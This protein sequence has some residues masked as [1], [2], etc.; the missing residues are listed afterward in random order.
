MYRTFSAD[1]DTYITDKVIKGVRVT[2]SNVG[3]AAT[4][5]LFKLYGATLSGTIP[6]IELSR[7]LIHFDIDKIKQLYAEKKIDIEDPNFWCRI[8]LKDV[9]GGQPTPANFNVHVFPLSASFDEGIGRDVTYYT[10]RDKSNW[11]SS[12][13][14]TKWFVSGCGG[15]CFST[16]SGDYITSS[17]STGSTKV[18]QYFKV[19]TEDLVVDVTKLV[20]A[21]VVGEL[22][23]SGFRISFDNAIE[24]NNRSYF[25]KRFGS[26][27]AYDETVRPKL[28]MG[29]DDSVRDDT[30]N[31]TFDSSCR[32]SLYNFF[33]GEQKNIVSGSGLTEVKGNNCILLKLSTSSSN[34]VYELI[35]TGS[36]LA[37]GSGNWCYVSGAYF[38]D[39]VLPSNNPIIKSNLLASSS[40]KFTPI[41]SSLDGTVGYVTG[42]VVTA[43]PPVRS[44]ARP[45]SNY[46]VNVKEVKSDY[47]HEEE[48][49]F[50]VEIFDRNTPFVKVVKVPVELP[51]KVLKNVH[52]QVR[53]AVT[54]EVVLPFDLTRMSTKVSSDSEGMFF[55]FDMSS[56]TPNSTYVFDV[57]IDVNGIKKA[58]HNV[59]PV[60]TVT[61]GT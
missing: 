19:G 13:V 29:F 21:T 53:N 22:P 12:S 25:V 35:A 43:H 15:A 26:R 41:W 10:D 1:K 51:G 55:N 6:N 32:L 61:D 4:L 16:G 60:F 7:I 34:G 14:T 46:Y 52:Y 56:L 24:A 40:V 2:G 47:S 39:F 48:T 44:A 57:L 54:N 36:Q 42:S 3:D 49:Q 28:T 27:N 58:H 45:T 18:S 9:Y 20:S 31:L 33:S 17:L 50:R 11:I 23:D 5:D 59:S 8:H 30:Q 37:L 38:A